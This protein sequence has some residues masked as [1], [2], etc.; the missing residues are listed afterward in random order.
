MMNT[1]SMPLRTALLVITIATAVLSRAQQDPMYSM[2]MWNMLSVQPGYAGSADVLNATALSRVQWAAING[3]PVTHS[4]SAHAPINMRSLGAGG[5][6]V[7]DRIGRTYTTSAFVDIAYRMRITRKT[8]LALGLKGGINHATIANTQV[9]NTDPNDPTFMA[10]MSGKVHPNFGF[11]A[12][13]WSRKGY[14]GISVPKLL[15]NYLG[16]VSADGIVTRFQQEA[17]HL[18]ITG[19]YVFPM[20]TVKFRPSIMVRATEGAPLSG[21]LSA[22][23]FFQDKF[24]LGAAYRHG[25][26]V[27]GI[28][29]VQLTDQIKA[30]YAYDFGVNTLTYRANGAHEVMIS[31][32]PVF[33]RERVR[34]PR[35]F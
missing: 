18:F 35:Y 14:L 24:S 32:D 28:L 22:N 33:T 26:S 5:S 12:Y 4:L 16:K 20:G 30:G 3:A 34:S 9:E 6:L 27:I 29:S 21:D 8:R 25:D 10:D 15:R 7:H 1:S 2:Y 17:S 13:L 23:F 19:G 31:Y 11:G